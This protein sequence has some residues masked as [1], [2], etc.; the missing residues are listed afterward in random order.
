MVVVKYGLWKRDV[1]DA[2]LKTK[3]TRNMFFWVFSFTEFWFICCRKMSKTV[4][5]VLVCWLLTLA[6]VACSTATRTGYPRSNRGFKSQGLSTARGKLSLII[7]DLRF[8]FRLIL[9]CAVMRWL[10]THKCSR[11]RETGPR[12]QSGSRRFRGPPTTRS[13]AT[14]QRGRSPVPKLWP[15]AS[16]SDAAR[17]KISSLQCLKTSLPFSAV[18]PTAGW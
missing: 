12:T 8:P 3:V 14:S 16:V 11:F 6:V 9:R 13:A 4:Q 18:T 15:H 17:I 5:Y 1:N 7:Y 2:I 10:M